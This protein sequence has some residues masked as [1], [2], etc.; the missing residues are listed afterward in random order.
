MTK[1]VAAIGAVTALVGAVHELV[2]AARLGGKTDASVA[3]E[4]V[5][6]HYYAALMECQEGK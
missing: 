5:A 2:D 4:F 1:I 6:R 3:C